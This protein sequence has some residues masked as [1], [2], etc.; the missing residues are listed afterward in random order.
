MDEP[1]RVLMLEDSRADAKLILR[2]LKEQGFDPIH[3]RVCDPD[4]VSIALKEEWDVVLS[5]FA[6]P[7][8]TALDAL[9]MLRERQLDLPFIIISGAVGEETAVTAMK[10]G[11]HSI[12]VKGRLQR[13]GQTIRREIKAAQTRIEAREADD[14]A[15]HLNRVLRA[16]SGVNRLIV[17][18]KD[19]SLLLQQAC[20]ILVETRDYEAVWIAGGVERTLP[21]LI[22]QSGRGESLDSFVA[23][24]RQGTPPPCLR[25]ASSSDEEVTILEERPHCEGCHLGGFCARF[26]SALVPLRYQT[27]SLGMLGVT[28]AEDHL[29]GPE[30]EAM[31]LEVAD[32]IAFALHNID[33]EQRMSRY[34][35]IVASSAE[36]MALMDR[37]HVY[38][39]AN[40]SYRR[41]VLQ[42]D[43]ELCG[44]K[45]SDVMGEAYYRAQ[46]KPALDRCFAGE[47]VRLETTSH[48]AGQDKVVEAICTPCNLPDGTI[49]AA[50]VCL[51][52]VTE[53][54]KIEES[55]RE[56]EE[57]F[58]SMFETAASLI[59]SV[60]ASGMIVDCN[61]RISSVLGYTREEIV[62]RSMETI[63]HPDYHQKAFDSLAEILSN[64]YSYGKDYKMVPKSGEPVDVLI[65]SS[66]L[67]NK[68]G[69]LYRT[70]CIIEDVTE[71]KRL[72]YQIAQSDRL[73]SMGMLAAGVAH[74][75]NNPLSYVLYSLQS[76][77]EDLPEMIAGL[78]D[79]HCT[80]QELREKLESKP[81][82]TDDLSAEWQD[83]LSRV[84]EAL[85]GTERI[86]D[87]ARGLGTFSRVENDVCVPVDLNDVVD[88]A[89]S[90]ATNEIKYRAK[91]TKDLAKIP[92]VMASDGRLSQVFLNLLINATHALDE[93]GVEENEIK[94]RTWVEAGHVCA[95][96]SDTGNGIE[97]LH[98]DKLFDP[99]FTTKKVGVGSGLGLSISKNI[100]E[101]YGGT[102]AVESEVGRGTRFTIKIPF[103]ERSEGAAVTEERLSPAQTTPGRILVIDDEECI[104]SATVRIL[105][106]H[107][108]ITASSGA[109]AKEF[110][111]KDQDFDLLLC[112]VMMSDMSGVELH[113]WISR[114]HPA[115]ANQVVFITGGAFTPRTRE[116]LGA[117]DNAC[118]EK[119]FDS[120]EL[121]MAV[122][123]L[124][125]EGR[126][127]RCDGK[128]RDAE[129]SQ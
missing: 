104:R 29:V 60:D 69:E 114:E 23:L 16:V 7:R 11:A 125:R 108:T 32:D 58:R 83:V 54:R 82:D 3:Q 52:D 84:G 99:F 123:D 95:E 26:Q 76:L 17:R 4:A 109:E 127:G 51:H 47:V 128:E 103:E 110:L 40:P 45:V 111:A 74:E 129:G 79:R 113:E 81:A 97:P 120:K 13:L 70:I 38:L 19:P 55:L 42:G 50:A 121:Q 46:I 91:M 112:D 10:A 30:E 28:L 68:A 122:A 117:L 57:R 33:V 44:R 115:L 1:L 61:Q 36:A 34:A 21:P 24:L 31:L 66:G 63:I 107:E 126:G 49:D 48:F 67:K 87:I 119:P 85:H 9:A 37:D 100:V 5:D 20:S 64:G 8:L 41:L 106:D 78:S 6:M 94:V 124:V 71:R 102:I 88:V 14:R 77:A 25:D 43:V 92:P 73:A 86:R 101:S 15:E 59:T 12:L 98:L 96:V 35:R 18:E 56:S 2:A 62:G 105:K 72:R 27:N 22:A 80:H 116:Y 118:F 39:E 93:G 65:N 53:R 90:M 89:V 75:I